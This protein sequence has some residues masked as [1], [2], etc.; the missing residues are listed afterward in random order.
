VANCKLD[1]ARKWNEDV[2]KE[3]IEPWSPFAD[4]N[5]SLPNP[6]P[7]CS[8]VDQAQSY[9]RLCMKTAGYE[10]AEQCS[11]DRFKSFGRKCYVAWGFSQVFDTLMESDLLSDTAQAPWVGYAWHK[12]DKSL[13]WV[14]SYAT[15]SDCINKLKHIISDDL[16]NSQFYSAP[17]GCAYNGNSYWRVRFMNALW[18]GKELGCIATSGEP[19]E[20]TD[21][22]ML[23]GPVL[24]RESPRPAGAKW[25]CV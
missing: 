16:F 1:V 21:I 20:A 3:C 10:F 2:M 4:S 13:E 9:M 25:H 14:N 17:I 15:H 22:G 8:D 5:A 23:Y 19:K 11:D 12:G 24:G 6:M 18:G 7:K